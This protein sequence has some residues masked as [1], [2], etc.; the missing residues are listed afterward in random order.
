MSVRLAHASI[1]ENGTI[2]GTAGDQTGKEVCIRNW[3]DHSKDW[4]LIRCTDPKMRPYI[5]EAGEKAAKNDNIGY[6]Q[7][8]NQDLW[9]DVK[10]NGFD[11]S[12]ADDPTETD[13][14]RLVRVCVQYAC[15][16]VGNGIK[17]PDF[18]TASE[19][20]ALKKTGLFKVYTASK[21]IHSDKL[22][23]RGDILC[24]SVKGHT[25]IVLDNGDDAEEEAVGTTT[26]SKNTSYVGK[27]IGTATAKQAMNI[28]SGAGTS[29]SSYGVIKKGT[30]V[31]VLEKNN[32]GWLK[33]AYPS[34]DKGY[35]YTS[36]RNEAYYSF[37]E[38]TS[39]ISGAY[40]TTGKL[41]M[42]Y[43]AGTDNKVL[44]VIPKGKTVVCTGKY[45]VVNG[46]KWLQVTYN[47]MAGYCSS[48]YLDKK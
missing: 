21:Y 16:K 7:L 26:N 36:N 33:I 9:D 12:K 2:R 17:V 3:Y 44:T 6:D 19:A 31:E 39:L 23:L 34:C 20:T 28:R 18:Y 47:G 5:A 11:P 25:A 37:V 24:T 32:N 10:D 8:Q 30:Q 27:G 13:C 29:Y 35:A 14:A 45:Q 42:R 48:V 4:V 40:V 46:T 1:S 22:L 15:V 38:N 43:G 41:N